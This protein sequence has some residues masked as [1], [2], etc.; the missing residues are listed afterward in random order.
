MISYKYKKYKSKYLNAVSGG[1]AQLSA[2]E[3]PTTGTKI[4]IVL[5]ALSGEIIYQF[6]SSKL[7]KD[8]TYH[9]IIN[10]LLDNYKDKSIT[11]ILTGAII[12]E[13][14]ILSLYSSEDKI[15]RTGRINR[16]LTTKLC[17]FMGLSE[18]HQVTGLL[19]LYF[20]FGSVVENLDDREEV[21]LRSDTARGISKRFLESHDDTQ[22][23]LI[24][25]DDIEKLLL[26][27]STDISMT[28]YLALY[29]ILLGDTSLPEQVSAFCFMSILYQNNE[30]IRRVHT[31][32][33][34]ITPSNFLN[35]INFWKDHFKHSLNKYD[36]LIEI[37]KYTDHEI[38]NNEEVLLH[39]INNISLRD[40]YN[41]LIQINNLLL[42]QNLPEMRIYDQVLTR[43]LHD[44]VLS[45]DKTKYNELVPETHI[46]SDFLTSL[47]L[48]P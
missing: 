41:R 4:S 5:R 15:D 42:Q 28:M 6:E 33:K 46:N 48:E 22:R 24:I 2:L 16:I 3:K 43:K 11:S 45:M 10:E 17:D 12:Y 9:D 34:N 26:V 8:I 47:I 18:E 21:Y 35:L 32:D 39:I 23:V 40:Y 1:A 37:M 38:Y 14:E 31:T 13:K 36:N 20:S 44:F 29:L 7:F 19:E 30:N 25:T 27:Y